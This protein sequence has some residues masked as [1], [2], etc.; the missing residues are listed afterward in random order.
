MLRLP[1]LRY[2]R[3]RSLDEAC[4]MAAAESGSMFIAGGTD[5]VPNLK[6]RQFEASTL[7]SLNALSGLDRIA[8]TDENGLVI[9]AGA[10]LDDIAGHPRLQAEYRAMAQA[11]GGALS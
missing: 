11:C 7:I 3:P 2:L 1:R 4:E 9:G 5:L 8:G 6:R 10:R